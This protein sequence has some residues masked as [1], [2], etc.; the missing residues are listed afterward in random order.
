ME[1]HLLV[2]TRGEPFQGSLFLEGKRWTLSP[3]L[4]LENN[5][6]HPRYACISYRWGT[7]TEPHALI[8]GLTMSAQTLPSLTAAIRTSE[9]N[10]FW[11]DI[12][13]VP[14]S[15]FERQATLE[16]MGYIYSR[17]AEVIVV[18]GESTF[19]VIQ[20]MMNGGPVDGSDLRIMEHD[21]WVA[22][23]WTY[24]EIVNASSFR[25][26]SATNQVD[27]LKSVSIEG[28]EFLN[29]LGFS[30][31]RWQSSTSSDA[32]DTTRTFP[33]L[34]ALE[35]ILADWETAAY[36]RRS[37]YSVL[38]S[39]ASKHNPDPANYFYA[40]F[41]VLSQSPQDLAWDPRQDF[42]EK[43]MAICEQ[44]NDFSFIYSVAARD[45]DPRFCW[46]PRASV[47]PVVGTN[48]PAVLRPI[49]AWHVWGEAQ[50]GHYDE[51]GFW[52][53]GMTVMHPASNVDDA[54]RKAIFDWLR[55]PESEHIDDITIGRL[56]DAAISSVGFQGRAEPI[57]VTEGMIFTLDIPRGASIARIL[58]SNQ[59]RYTMGAPG[60]VQ[61]GDKDEKQYLPCLFIGTVARLLGGGESVLL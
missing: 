33:N 23:V 58:V 45:T 52:L 34:N 12:F 21:E 50:E 9:L 49:F 47:L 43:F 38:C 60:L 29:S 22:S 48:V 14:A 55:R 16:R 5:P 6:H 39:M 46:R 25:F 7:A 15:G 44:K 18:L 1:I 20:N 42:A 40:I 54:G 53:D 35:N 26:V 30:L 31:M 24:Q 19:S 27:N 28:S 13:C 37:A 32:F 56:L 41:G 36:L 11:T 10:A 2:E 8:E 61:I 4:E 57:I 59:I 3:P 51:S 17:A